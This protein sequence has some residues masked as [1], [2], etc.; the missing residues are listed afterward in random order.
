MQTVHL[1]NVFTR[2][3][4]VAF[5]LLCG[6]GRLA[7]AQGNLGRTKVHPS[8]VDATMSDR[9][10][11]VD[12]DAQG[13][14]SWHEHRQWK[15]LTDYGMDYHS[16]P[17]VLFDSARQ[18]LHVEL[19]RTTMVDGTQVDTP[20][21]GRN[22]LMP[23]PLV[24]A[25]AYASLRRTII[26]MVGIEPNAQAELRFSVSDNTAT[27]WSPGGAVPI[28][29]PMPTEHTKV[30][31]TTARGTLR[32]ACVRC[33]QA[34][35]PQS[36]SSHVFELNDL[37]PLDT[38]ELGPHAG[39]GRLP[40]RF[41][42]RIVFSTAESWETE[43]RALAE[44]VDRAAGPTDVLHARAQELIRDQVSMLSR[45]EAIQTFVA[46]HVDTVFFE[47]HR[48]GFAPATAETI[49][50]RSHGSAL[51]KAVLLTALLRA[52][53]INAHVVLLS[54]DTAFAEDVPWLGQ[55]ERAWVVAE[56]EGQQLWMPPC[57]AMVL[58]RAAFLGQCVALFLA[59]PAAPPVFI[60][61]PA[62]EQNALRLVAELTLTAEGGLS[63]QIGLS[64]SGAV[65]PYFNLRSAGTGAQGVLP[66]VAS[67]FGGQADQVTIEGFSPFGTAVRG[68]LSHTLAQE[69]VPMHA[70]PLPW[71]PG[72]PFANLSLRDERQTP[73]EMRGPGVQ[74]SR[75]TFHLPA[76]WE[77]AGLPEPVSINNEMGSLVQTVTASE[78]GTVEI[79]REL[80]I[81]KRV[82]EPGEYPAL[83]QL[84]VT[85]AQLDG[86]VLLVT[87]AQQ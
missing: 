29:G 82:V 17:E 21:S 24:D 19:A 3:S 87:P 58:P 30:A 77:P 46:D 4:L 69:P 12:I 5:I 73:L 14:A 49:L 56:V 1:L 20:D 26:S 83:R 62:P 54:R 85:A 60:D 72:G 75:L 48:L 45:V 32:S 23:G 55:F 36:G 53:N 18:K 41:V 7:N 6:C 39:D 80:S 52:I 2:A 78:D 16:D 70:L 59:D 28:S 64:A 11:K 50:S 84:L 10:V 65:N 68:S 63:G 71:P 57:R 76:D 81:T 66:P 25:P 42:P 34:L 74:S 15:I 47:L 35:P 8:G 43:T 79:F 38:Y 61:P 40:T 51:E 86:Q 9:A 67:A 37:A 33:S 44:R 22:E 31:L 13:R 27:P